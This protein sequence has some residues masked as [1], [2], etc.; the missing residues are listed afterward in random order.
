MVAAYGQVSTGYWPALVIG[1][2]L[3]G[4]GAAYLVAALRRALRRHQAANAPRVL[5]RPLPEPWQEAATPIQRCRGLIAEALIVRDR[6]SGQIDA[7]TYRDRM[8]GLALK[9]AYE[10][11]PHH[12]AR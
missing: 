11:R 1:T 8:S 5:T 2:V 12:D 6:L 9:A 7:Y 10:R 4:A 3:L